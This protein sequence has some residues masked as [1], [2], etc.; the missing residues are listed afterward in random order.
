MLFFFDIF[1]E[2]TKKKRNQKK[3]KMPTSSTSSLSPQ[4][5]SP[6]AINAAQNVHNNTTRLRGISFSERMYRVLALIEFDEN[7]GATCVW[8]DTS[9]VEVVIRGVTHVTLSHNSAKDILNAAT[10]VAT[11]ATGTA[12]GALGGSGSTTGGGGGSSYPAG[13]GGGG[14]GSHGNTQGGGGGGGGHNPSHN[15]N[16]APG[17]ALLGNVYSNQNSNC[18]PTYQVEEVRGLPRENLFSTELEAACK[19]VANAFIQCDVNS[20]PAQSLVPQAQAQLQEQERQREK[21]QS[22]QQQH[23]TTE[24]SMHTKSPQMSISY[25]ETPMTSTVMSGN[26]HHNNNNQNNLFGHNGTANHVTSNNNNT[27]TTTSSSS[28]ISDL[29]FVQFSDIISPVAATATDQYVSKR[30]H[31]DDSAKAGGIPHFV[32]ATA[33]RF[34]VPDAFARGFSRLF[35]LM[36]CTLVKASSDFNQELLNAACCSRHTL[37]MYDCMTLFVEKAKSCFE[38]RYSKF[39]PMTIEKIDAYLNR[40]Q[41]VGP[42]PGGPS[43][44]RLDDVRGLL[45]VAPKPCSVNNNN[46]NNNFSNNNNNN[47]SNNN[48][49]DQDSS[50]F[51][52]FM[53][54]TEIR[55]STESLRE[56]LQAQV[57]VMKEKE[58]RERQE[59]E[60]SERQQRLLDDEEKNCDKNE[61]MSDKQQNKKK[62]TTTTQENDDDD[63]GD[64]RIDEDENED[65]EEGDDEESKRRRARKSSSK[66][67]NENNTQQS[68][69]LTHISDSACRPINEEEGEQDRKEAA[70]TNENIAAA[71][72]TAHFSPVASPTTVYSIATDPLRPQNQDVLLQWCLKRGG[73]GNLA[74]F[75][76]VLEL[77]GGDEAFE[78]RDFFVDMC[79]FGKL[80]EFMKGAAGRNNSNNNINNNN[81]NNTSSKPSRR[82]PFGQPPPPNAALEALFCSLQENF[83][84][85]VFFGDFASSFPSL[86]S[87]EEE[88]IN[89]SVG[90]P[91]LNVYTT[92]LSQPPIS[93]LFSDSYGGAGGGRRDE[94]LVDPALTED[95]FAWAGLLWNGTEHL[96]VLKS[97]N[98]IASNTNT[99]CIPG[100]HFFA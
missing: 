93:G 63:N 18:C 43:Q 40:I 3:K 14:T 72:P 1:C 53:I 81:N 92:R 84:E 7:E 77:Y 35:V 30:S 83:S 19:K 55:E 73:R 38:Y 26:H 23:Q 91:I 74:S 4:Q 99:L 29:H 88:G 56:K 96:K 37:D 64:V 68:G 58:E 21:R 51:L 87:N 25:P 61:E 36:S 10:A 15:H 98:S 45:A 6:A 94:C 86:A 12:G 47:S 71:T 100:T 66:Q 97:Q 69:G 67:D 5:Q 22:Q 82:V 54:E 8:N 41:E 32:R 76:R 70:S 48:Q 52:S 42:L 85:N 24:S 89:S 9:G 78:I 20:E 28:S 50:S 79:A 59:R 11:G 27:T 65:G 2:R 31:R 62:N 80:P 57:I 44:G 49:D 46:F 39:L 17:I 95:P 90:G 33:C 13:G 60:V 34:E 16:G 75:E